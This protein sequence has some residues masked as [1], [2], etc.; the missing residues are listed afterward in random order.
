MYPDSIKNRFTA[1]VE[2]FNCAHFFECHDTLED[3]WFDVKG[4]ERFF[5]QGL[6]HIA[7]GFY[8]FGNS[9]FRGAQSQLR[10]ARKKLEPFGRIYQGVMLTD[11]LE[12][13]D[14]YLQTALQNIENGQS[15]FP[16]VNYPKIKWQDHLFISRHKLNTTQ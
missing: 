1:A 14:P 7:V 5:Y 16:G 2:Q 8:H 15:E 11:I 13:T 12:Q 9:N 4:K 10:K 6:L 3:I